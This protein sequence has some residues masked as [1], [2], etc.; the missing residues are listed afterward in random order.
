MKGWRPGFVGADVRR[1]FK[2]QKWEQAAVQK[3]NYLQQFKQLGLTGLVK[4][5]TIKKKDIW[6]FLDLFWKPFL[7]Y[8]SW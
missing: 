8:F 1:C 5:K 4:N 3:V 6:F 2:A 7:P